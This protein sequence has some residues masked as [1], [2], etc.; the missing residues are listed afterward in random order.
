MAL[1]PYS[2]GGKYPGQSGHK[3]VEKPLGPLFALALLPDSLE[4]SW[5]G[6]LVG[7]VPANQ[8][9]GHKAIEKSLK[10]TS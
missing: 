8:Q 6:G 4:S 1:W 3:A 7:I 2:L 10:A 9:L 5:W